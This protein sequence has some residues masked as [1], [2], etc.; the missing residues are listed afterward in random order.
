MPAEEVTPG[1]R[2]WTAPHPDLAERVWCTYVEVADATVL[3]DPLVPRD[4]DEPFLRAL[5]ADVERRGL[6]VQI[7][8]SARQHRR[9]ADELSTRYG[10]EIW[11]GS[12]ALPAG[13]ETFPV[14]HPKPVERPFWLSSHR[15]LVFGDALQV[16]DGELRVWWDRRWKVGEDW[17]RDRLLPSLRPMLDLPVEHVLTGHGP[18]VAGAELAAALDRPPYK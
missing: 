8:L 10:A 12:G 2:V 7:L 3:V 5:D 18:P 4:D 16:V 6:P 17:Y 14:E 1:L 11:D 15:A 9:S 13:V